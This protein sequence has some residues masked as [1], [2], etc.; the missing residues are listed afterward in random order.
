[1]V[2]LPVIECLQQFFCES[3]SWLVGEKHNSNPP[4]ISSLFSAPLTLFKFQNLSQKFLISGSPFFHFIKDCGLRF[5][6]SLTNTWHKKS[7]EKLKFFV[8]ASIFIVPSNGVTI[9]NMRFSTTSLH[10]SRSINLVYYIQNEGLKWRMH[11][12]ERLHS[13]H[14]RVSKIRLLVSGLDWRQQFFHSICATFSPGNIRN[15][16]QALVN[17]SSRRTAKN[18]FHQHRRKNFRKSWK[19]FGSRPEQRCCMTSSASRGFMVFLQGWVGSL[20]KNFAQ[21]CRIQQIY[22]VP[23]IEFV[24][25]G[26]VWKWTPYRF[27]ENPTLLRCLRNID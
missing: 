16:K 8:F 24:V 6:L 25:F 18:H 20:D 22:G 19:N 17:L 11:G 23:M 3:Y 2:T 5:H 7:G 4:T 1:M 14:H 13:R 27:H 9:W 12:D 26:R 21:V 10:R 15:F